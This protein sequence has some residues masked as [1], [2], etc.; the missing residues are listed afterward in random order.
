MIHAFS[1]AP[2]HGERAVA[3]GLHLSF[4][5][6]VT[7]PRATRVRETARQVP[8]ER[9]LLETDS[10]DQPFTP[11]TRG[12]PRDL[13]F[14]ASAIGQLRGLDPTRLLQQTGDTARR[15]FGPTPRSAS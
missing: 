6:L 7:R 10:P 4:G 1:G 13:R 15:L 3:L 9:L 14:V 11:K 12:E 8:L 2:A 5:S